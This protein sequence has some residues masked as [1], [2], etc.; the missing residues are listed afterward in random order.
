MTDWTQRQRRRVMPL[1]GP[2]LDAWEGVP[3]DIKSD[4][5]EHC[6]ALH[7]LLNMINKAMEE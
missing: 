6:E 1:I 5:H 2:L 3:N 4:L 7:S